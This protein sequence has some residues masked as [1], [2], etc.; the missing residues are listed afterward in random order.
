MGQK[1]MGRRDFLK[2]SAARIKDVV[3]FREVPPEFIA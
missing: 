2:S 1:G 3:H